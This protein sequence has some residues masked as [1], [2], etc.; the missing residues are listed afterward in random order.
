MPAMARLA[1]M[2]GVIRS[3]GLVPFARRVYS[4]IADD[5]LYTWASALAY[6]WLLAVFPFFIFLLTF[7]PQLPA[8]L[9]AEAE[10]EVRRMVYE[11]A[12]GHDAARTLWENIHDNVHNL[13][14][15]RQGRTW[16]RLLG[17]VFA[18]WAASGGMSVTLAALDK[19]YDLDKR[20]PYYRQ[21]LIAVGLTLLATALLLVV[22]S[23]L[24]VGTL[25][26]NWLIRTHRLSAGPQARWAFDVPRFGLSILFLFV[27]LALLYHFGPGIK[28][29]FV[30]LSPGS[31][32]T[33]TV[34]LALALV[35]K[36]YVEKYGRYGQTYGTVGGVAVLLLVFYIDALVLL[37][38]AEINSEVDFEVLGVCRGTNDF[39]K[40]Q[41]FN[42]APPTAM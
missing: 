30:W 38:G 33:V 40:P 12:P 24:P 34:W 6:A 39:S 2:P 26:R 35:F 3:V 36:V 31:V 7:L 1:D 37:I 14:H 11:A 23:L 5:D 18:V 4:E 17:L 41:D 15:E 13:L 9:Q 19:C 29:R 27:M 20:R 25:A 42:T 10:R 22:V 32:F 8:S 16:P 21:R 28:H